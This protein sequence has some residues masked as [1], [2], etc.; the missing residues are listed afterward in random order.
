MAKRNI[1]LN[2]AGNL[3]LD[4]FGM[5]PTKQQEEAGVPEIG[6]LSV[7]NSIKKKDGAV[8]SIIG[9]PTMGKTVCSY[10]LAEI[11]G[12][13]TYAVSPA[14][15]PPSWVQPLKIE[16]LD[17]KPPKYST[18]ILDD[19]VLYM[20]SRDYNDPFVEALEKLAPV[21]RHERK[22]ILIFNTQMA[23]LTDKYALTGELIILKAPSI[24]YADLERPMVKK[25]QDRA[26]AYWEG[27]SEKWLQKHAYIISHFW[28][29]IVSI[30]LPSVSQVHTVV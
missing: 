22:L 28:A 27:K 7:V 19:I 30:N 26:Y 29:G 14:A 15:K 25:L 2:I 24:L 16:E 3:L 12:R 4:Y 5:Q 23:S 21:A 20:S 8:I 18:L 9:A 6:D 1:L 17:T 13:P 10:R 11:F